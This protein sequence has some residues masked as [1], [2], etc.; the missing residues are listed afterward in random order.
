MKRIVALIIAATL[1]IVGIGFSFMNVMLST[2]F[3]DL[4]QLEGTDAVPKSIY[5]AGNPANTIAVVNVEGTILNQPASPL[6]AASYNHELTLAALEEIRDDAS[7]KGVLLNV[8]SPGGGVY[9][10]AEIYRLLM[11]IK[12][13]D[14]IIYSTMGNMA[15]SGGYYISAPADK[16][17]ASNETLTG[18]IGVIMSGLNMSELFDDLGIEET[19]WTSGDM[20]NMG[21]MFSPMTEEEDEYF[22]YLTESMHDDFVNAIVEGRGMD[23]DDVR[24]LADGRIYLAADAIENGL[25]DEIGNFN[26]AL[27]A[28]KEE[29]GERAHVVE[30]AVFDTNPLLGIPIPGLKETLGNM[31]FDEQV[32]VDYLTHLNLHPRPMYLYNN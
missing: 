7:V 32:M 25:I 26:T 1:F 3:E 17:Y 12:A 5:E 13:Q 14:K 29:V 31:L 8:D 10:S 27:D 28:L 4:L 30:Y 24:E 16:I 20:K 15:A 18:S 21:S 23:E 22:Q 6:S 9:E 2:N 11:D 19:T